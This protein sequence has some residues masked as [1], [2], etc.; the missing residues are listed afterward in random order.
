MKKSSLFFVVLLSL[1]FVLPSVVPAREKLSNDVVWVKRSEAYKC[2]VQ[3]A[4]LNAM[5]RLRDLAKDKKVGTWCVV[6]DADE[7]VISNVAFQMTG[8]SYS[9]KR[10]TQWCEK[11]AATL[12][13][14]AKE[15]C[16]LARELGGKVIIVT[17]RKGHLQA[18]TVENFNNL[19]FP[20][21]VI[22]TRGGAYAK[23]RT[24]VMRREA[25]RKGTIKTLPA[26]M[27]LPPLEI[28][29]LAGD[30]THDLY[31]GHKLNF[32]DVKDRF[33]KDL[34]IIPNPMYG[35][36]SRPSMYPESYSSSSISRPSSSTSSKPVTADKEIISSSGAITAEEALTRVGEKVVV[37]TEI[38]S[39]YDPASR[40]KGG[41]VKLNTSRDWNKGLTIVIFNKDGSF[42]DPSRFDGKKVRAT[43][44]VGTYRDA[45][46][47]TISKPDDIEVIEE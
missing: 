11:S 15:F 5:D 25:I 30:Q 13:P 45:V 12:L 20:Y 8:L 42:G 1:L 39:V 46:Q 17:N 19:D 4:Y 28:V 37:E 7:T 2:C 43:G 44:K 16:G 41:P 26:G 9:S 24:K 47:L 22:L 38:V 29:M 6:L 35:S 14:G 34:I 21:D 27:K 33:A 40:G 18:V 23:D 31:D 32:E 3:Q 36:W 10:W